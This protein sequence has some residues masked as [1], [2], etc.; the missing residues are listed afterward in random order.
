M[1]T[2]VAR[3]MSYDWG[4]YVLKDDIYCFFRGYEFL[5]LVV[6]ENILPNESFSERY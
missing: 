1:A 4:T 5:N 2:I 3:K 6:Y